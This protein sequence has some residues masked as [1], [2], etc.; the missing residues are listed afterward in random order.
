[1]AVPIF[2]DFMAEA[3]ERRNAVPFR[4]PP[5]IRLVR[6]NAD[7]GLLAKPGD[8]NVILEAFIPGT[9]PFG[10]QLVLDGQGFIRLDAETDTT[11]IY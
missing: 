5:G 1:V 8:K 10:E 2:R 11:G 3:L 6:I 7:T 4:V 9:E